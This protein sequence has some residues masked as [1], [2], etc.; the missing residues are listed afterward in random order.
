MTPGSVLTLQNN[1]RYVLIRNFFPLQPNGC[2][3]VAVIPAPS[4]DESLSETNVRFCPMNK[5]LSSSA[6]MYDVS[7]IGEGFDQGRILAKRVTIGAPNKQLRPKNKRRAIV[8]PKIEYT[9]SLQKEEEAR[10]KKQKENAKKKAEAKRKEVILLA[11]S[12]S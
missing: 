8:K 1:K 4:S 9:E 7:D 2:Y 3:Y 12:L 11:S 6:T 5:V 10:A